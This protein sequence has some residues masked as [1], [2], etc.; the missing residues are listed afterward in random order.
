MSG[1]KD[2][3]SEETEMRQVWGA[4][5]PLLCAPALRDGPP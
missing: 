3:E 1:S 4:L 2:G 5:G